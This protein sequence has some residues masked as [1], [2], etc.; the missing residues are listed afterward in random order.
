MTDTTEYLSEL[1]GKSG[2]ARN[3]KNKNTWGIQNCTMTVHKHF[4]RLF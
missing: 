3:Y 4:E 1:S 2:N